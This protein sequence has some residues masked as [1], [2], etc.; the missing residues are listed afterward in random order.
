M[1]LVLHPSMELD[2][3]RARLFGRLPLGALQLRADQGP[4][5]HP[6]WRQRDVPRPLRHAGEPGIVLLHG[7]GNVF[8]RMLGAGEKILVEPGGY[9][10]KDS[11]VNMQAVQLNVRTGLLRPGMYMAEMTGPGRVGIQSMYHH[12]ASG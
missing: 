9:L 3:A 10:Y 12:H 2:A 4:L 5:E 1:T 11:S 6:P 8:E 7:Y